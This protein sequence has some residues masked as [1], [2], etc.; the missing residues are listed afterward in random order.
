M[1]ILISGGHITPA[2]AV[3][4]ELKKKPVDI[5]VVGRQFA[6]SNEPSF[7]YQEVKNRGVRFLNLDAGR[8]NRTVK[9]L[10]VISMAKIPLGFVGAFNIMRKEKPDVVLSF[11]GYIAFPL[12]M[13]AKI[14]N[15]PVFTHEQTLVPGLANRIIGRLS[16]K[17][18]VSFGQ[19]KKYFPKDKVILSGNPL[20]PE[21][22]APKKK[23]SNQ[24]PMILIMGGSL[25]SH[26][27]NIIIET[28]LPRLLKKYLIIHQVGSVEEYGDFE[29]LNKL[30][31]ANYLVA[32]HF[33]SEELAANLKKADLVIARSGANTVIELVALSK[34]AILIPLP[35]SALGEQMAHAKL[36]VNAGAA[37]IFEQQGSPDK[38]LDLIDRM[39]INLSPYHTAFK[40]L[41]YLFNK[42]AA[43]IITDYLCSKEKLPLSLKK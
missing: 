7:E 21:I 38:L 16:Q 41:S 26:S 30:D 24:R 29:R 1:K 20:R 43:G 3:I 36:L 39:I 40:K 4:D 32:K 11:G 6:G 37:E 15:I 10:T 5:V 14:L 17:I 25:G 12:V 13:A 28:I 9:Y 23:L 42:Q 2:L 34:P 31:D 19:T 33:S 22:L 18:F 27:V 35:W 8:L